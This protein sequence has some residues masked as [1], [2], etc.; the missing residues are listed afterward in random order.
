MAIVISPADLDD[1][2]LAAFLTAH[3]A[4]MEPTAPEESRHALDL[5]G[6]RA[7]GVRLWVA[8]DTD[9]EE[10]GPVGTVATAPIPGAPPE[11][12]E[13]KSMRTDPARRGRGIGRMLLSHA[14]DDAASRGVR[15][16][17]LET[18]SMEFFAPA[19]ALYR[20][21]GFTDCPPFGDYRPDPLSTFLTRAL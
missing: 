4:D 19:R 2:A 10:T 7:P 9:A 5:E 3:L 13:L 11:H 21:H 17:S 18:G 12:E 14:L 1:L 6:L 8:Q 15:R 16:V 20:A